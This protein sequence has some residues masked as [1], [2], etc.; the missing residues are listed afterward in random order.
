MSTEVPFW[1][2]RE[3]AMCVG[4]VKL[5]LEGN[6]LLADFAKAVTSLSRLMISLAFD[7]APGVR[8]DW[9]LVNQETGGGVVTLEGRPR[10]MFRREA[11]KCIVEAYERL[12]ECLSA[13][14]E[15]PFSASVRRFAGEILSLTE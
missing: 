4:R 12:G 8:V 7:A 10:K 13:G 2:A 1:R 15:I 3:W 6:V 9:I 14:A 5:A 11:V